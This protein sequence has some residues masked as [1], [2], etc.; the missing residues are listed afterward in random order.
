MNN[1]EPLK[2]ILSFYN[3]AVNSIKNESYKGKKGVWWITTDSGLKVLKKVSNSEDTLKFT[4]Q[5]VSH[6]IKNGVNIPPINKTTE[7]KEY[8]NIDGICYV[9][10]DAI[11]GKNPSYSKNSELMLIIKGLSDFH[12][13]SYDFFP[14]EG[15]KPKKHLDTWIKNYTDDIL[16][17]KKFYELEIKSSSN[18]PISKLIISQFPYFYERALYYINKL[19]ENEYKSWVD[20]VKKTGG[21]CHQ[22]FAAGNLILSKNELYVLDTDSITIDIPARDLRKIFN[23]IMKKANGWNIETAKSIINCYQSENPLTADEWKVVKYDLMFPHLFIGAM[24]KY[25]YQRDKE[26]STQKYYE[27]IK[28]MAEFEREKSSMLEIFDFL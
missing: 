8:V 9:L 1:N 17:M 18:T 2:N 6:L 20:K 27:R 10:S 7:G 16:D 14:L 12:K 19:K 24:N 23:K 28:E 5:A 4:L 13:A 3:I 25:C 21:L 26:W 22:D 11:L 15:C